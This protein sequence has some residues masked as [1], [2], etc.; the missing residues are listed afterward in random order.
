MAYTD[1]FDT[2]QKIYIAY[3]QRPADPLGLI[4]WA[5]RLDV[6]NGNLNEIIDAFANSPEA[7]SL[8]GSIDENN[9]GNVIKAIY[10]AAFNRDPDPIGL[11]FYTN[12]FKEG[13]F[14]PATI[15][16][17]ILNGAQADDLIILNNKVQ[18]AINFTK[19]IDPE[20]DGENLL[21]TYAGN[22]D[23]Q[24]ARDFLKDVGA[25]ADT[26]KT[27][28]DAINF[29]KANIADPQDPILQ[30]GGS[31]DYIRTLTPQVEQFIGT[32][33]DDV[34]KAIATFNSSSGTYVDTLNSG[35]FIDGKGGYDKLEAL[36][37]ATGTIV[38]TLKNLEEIKWTS[39]DTSGRAKIDLSISDPVQKIVIST[40]AGNSTISNMNNIP[41]ISLENILNKN[42]TFSFLDSAFSN[43]RTIDISLTNSRINIL[44]LNNGNNSFSEIKFIANSGRNSVGSIG[45]N[46]QDAILDVNKVI[47]EGNGDISLNL[48][49]LTALTSIDASNFKGNSDIDIG[50]ISTDMNITGGEGNDIVNLGSN[51]DIKDKIDLGKGNDTLIVKGNLNSSTQKY[52]VTNVEN[53][54][55]STDGDITIL[56]NAFNSPFEK[57]TIVASNN[58]DGA[59]VSGLDQK[60]VIELQDKPND[61]GVNNIGNIN[62]SLD[63]ANASDDSLSIRVVAN[64]SSTDSDNNNLNEVTL[65]ALTIAGVETINLESTKSDIAKNV[66]NI[67]SSLSLTGTNN[68]K[69]T[70]DVNLTINN[71]LNINNIDASEFIADLSIDVA[72]KSAVGGSQT[73]KTGSG[74]DVIKILST[75]LDSTVSLDAGD[76]E[77][78]LIFGDKSKTTIDLSGLT[79]AKK[80]SNFSNLENLSVSN[81]SVTLK[82]DQALLN[83]FSNKTVNFKA[84]DVTGVTFD[85]SGVLSNDAIVNVDTSKISTGNNFTFII[86]NGKNTLIGG[87]GD[88]I[89][90]IN[91]PL[92]LDGNDSFN[93][94][95]GNNQI[96]FNNPDNPNEI[97]QIP[98]TSLEGF[99]GFSQI[100]INES[101]PTNSNK[102]EL[103]IS[104]NFIAN[105]VDTTTNQYTI[106]A[107]NLTSDYLSLDASDVSSIYKLEIKGSS[108][109]DTIKGGKGDDT[110]IG[111]GGN[112]NIDISTGGK[113]TI[114]FSSTT[115]GVDVINGFTLKGLDTTN[116]NYDKLDF[117]VLNNGTDMNI[118]DSNSDNIPDTLGKVPGGAAGSVLANNGVTVITGKGYD[119]ISQALSGVSNG[120]ID[121]PAGA[122]GL[123]VFYNTSTLKTEIYYFKDSDGGADYDAGEA[124]PYAQLS[125]VSLDDLPN[126]EA[127][128]F[129]V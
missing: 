112:D 115:D 56:A 125:N 58:S 93:G 89:V 23:A 2:V 43:N 6:S 59:T 86:S 129:I 48:N 30:T 47:L 69:I 33:G 61:G 12:G 74:N 13:K 16:L 24:K 28:D 44:D 96:V 99:K 10:Q 22:E 111:N 83:V 18:S 116:S 55:V 98:S 78:T 120:G 19:A 97:Y 42:V 4:Y 81:S 122:Q 92:F 118:T 62:L 29:I 51:F 63:N 41:A 121:I 106:D 65:N 1:Y 67:I 105:N 84:S 114:S 71:K 87:A 60:T 53:L 14:T 49:S 5:Q 88:D 32:D 102:V 46:T 11:E 35:D 8:Y 15:M 109:N 3:Y 34:I 110:I 85:T 54:T 73:I 39:M 7:Q 20:L 101:S 128:N 117:D 17:D 45:D 113:D 77:D 66:E 38:P 76:G 21:A 127:D 57:I 100:T 107:S 82:V 40:P 108:K 90:Q 25:T 103:S 123:V 79:N 52:D 104:N 95:N 70:G 72:G 37:Y 124:T 126:F 94:G 80:I 91:N 9:I 36:T 119:D 75:D 50:N 26:V 31:E 64:D 68:L 27:V